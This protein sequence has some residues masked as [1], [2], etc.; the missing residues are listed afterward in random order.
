MKTGA[1]WLLLGM[2]CIAT[3]DRVFGQSEFTKVILSTKDGNEIKGIPGFATLH[4]ES[5]LGT[6]DLPLCDVVSVTPR[7][8]EADVVLSDKSVIKG[9]L[10]LVEW[11]VETEFGPVSAKWENILA[12]RV[13]PNV[14]L[15][16]PPR[17]STLEDIRRSETAT[18]AISVL[19]PQRGVVLGAWPRSILQPSPDG[20]RLYIL[21]RGGKGRLLVFDLEKFQRV[22][23]VAIGREPLYRKVA[24]DMAPSGKYYFVAIGQ[25]VTVVDLGTLQISQSFD[26]QDDVDDVFALNDDSAYMAASNTLLSVSMR[27][28]STSKIADGGVGTFHP[29]PDRKKIY[30][31]HGSFPVPPKKDKNGCLV[32]QGFSQ[33]MDGTEFDISPDGKVAVWNRSVC[34][35]GKTAETD[36]IPIAKIPPNDARAFLPSRKRIFTSFYGVVHELDATNYAV[37]RTWVPGVY[38]VAAR[39]LGEGSVYVL[40]S[41]RD[42]GSCNLYRFELPPPESPP[43]K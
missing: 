27:T 2:F 39:A 43:P 1:K 26:V 16:I 38:I 29:T 5:S 19:R 15:W 13:F 42:G 20:K 4:V 22:A 35:L 14:E 23:T 21:E 8:E 33:S 40:G 6:H 3:S 37:T 24:G 32:R 36:M 30:T 9:R 28:K 17:E 25:Q 41:L 31:L 7:G 12:V 10:G 11:P 34:R 18:P